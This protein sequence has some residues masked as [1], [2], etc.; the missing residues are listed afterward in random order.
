MAG[1]DLNRTTSGV[2]LE[3]EESSEIISKAIEESVVMQMARRIALPGRG[4]AF[5]TITGDPEA[6]WVTQETNIKPKGVHTLGTKI[7]QGYTLAVIEPMSKQFRRD[8]AALVSELISRLPK[9]LGKK[10]DATVLTG[11]TADKPGDNFDIFAQVPQVDIATGGIYSGLVRADETINNADWLINGYV[12]SPKARAKLLNAKDDS[13]R[14][15]FLADL[16]TGDTGTILG[17]PVKFT[18][19][20]GKAATSTKAEQLG[21]A[22][23]WTKCAYGIV[24]DVQVDITDQASITIDNTNVNLWERNMFAVRAEIE[25]GFMIDFNDAFVRLTNGED[26]EANKKPVKKD[27][28]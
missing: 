17:S 28:K 19:R 13:N 14:P 25:I 10:F 7:M 23:D 6:A 20:V 18:N 27:G 15:L 8:K 3:K 9:A 5:Q 16:K 4:L 22:G 12:L 1:I 11:A 24:E 26:P 2:L 21:I